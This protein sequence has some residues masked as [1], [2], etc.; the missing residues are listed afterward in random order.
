MESY[1]SI[2]KK[3]TP[4]SIEHLEHGTFVTVLI[5]GIRVPVRVPDDFYDARLP[6]E[7]EGLEVIGYR[8]VDS[9]QGDLGTIKGIDDT[10]INIVA[11]LDNGILVPLHEDFIDEIDEDTKRLLITLP[12]LIE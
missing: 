3:Y 2:I 8:L 11:E 7:E 6:E 4:V 10:T 5:D 1:K 12:Y 9:K